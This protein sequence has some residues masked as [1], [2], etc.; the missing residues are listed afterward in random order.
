MNTIRNPLVNATHVLWK[1]PPKQKIVG[2]RTLMWG[3]PPRPSREGE[4]EQQTAS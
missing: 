4:A 2:E 1:T 3:R